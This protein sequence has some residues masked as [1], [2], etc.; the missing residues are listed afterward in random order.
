MGWRGRC[1]CAPGD[2]PPL[3][4]E[5]QQ[6]GEALDR[7]DGALSLCNA[8]RQSAVLEDRHSRLATSRSMGAGEYGGLYKVL[9]PFQ[10]Q[11]DGLEFLPGQLLDG[12][13][14]SAG[15]GAS[16]DGG[17]ALYRAFEFGKR[18][19][20]MASMQSIARLY[21]GQR[22]DLVQTSA[23]VPKDVSAQPSMLDMQTLAWQFPLRRRFGPPGRH[24]APP[25]MVA[26]RPRAFPK[27]A[28][29]SARWRCGCRAADARDGHA[30]V[31]AAGPA[32]RASDSWMRIQI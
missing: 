11:V 29:V 3:D 1:R 24:A 12:S 7:V 21:Q 20:V 28:A 13:L 27:A 22:T 31:F 17:A 10:C 6:L 16:V 26:S 23:Q 8:I 2:A 9:A 32:R 4:E 30:P 5:A 25:M 19:G 15:D 18:G 14:I